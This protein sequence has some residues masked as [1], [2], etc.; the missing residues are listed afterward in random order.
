MRSWPDRGLR[1]ALLAYRALMWLL[2]PAILLYLRKRGRADP[3]YAARLRERFGRYDAP[4]PGAVWVHAVSMGEMRSAVP[5]IR[6][7][8]DRG[9][10][11]VTTHFTPAGLREAE[12]AFGPEIAAGRLRAVWV[13]LEHGRCWDRFLDAFRPRF[14]LVMEIEIWPRMIAV[15]ARRGVPIYLCNAQY[16]EKSFE[17]DGRGEGLRARVVA[18][19]AGA[20]VKSQLQ[21]DRFAATGLRDIEI[22]GEHRFDQPI[23]QA[24]VAAADALRDELRRG[25]PALTLT[26]VVEGEDATYIE[27]IRATPGTVFVYVPRAPERFDEVAGLLSEAGLRV[28]RRSEVLDEGLRPKAPIDCDVLLGDSMGE[29]YFYMAL[30]DRALV[31]GG[32]V[33]KG[34]HNVIEPLAL[35]KPVL[36][37]PHVW[38]IEYPIREAAAAG[39]ARVLDTPEELHAAVAEASAVTEGQID[40]F[41]E[42]HAGAVARTLSAL[43]ARGLL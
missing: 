18:G 28:A 37:G 23:P 24:Q 3:L 33:P 21:A 11:I 25:R 36:V 27:M 30:S 42:A 4:L 22:T 40:A 10:Q 1:R 14:G 35:K 29:M 7:L 38:T 16:P 41:Y 34:A 13:P 31:G 19:F 5:M 32:F 12:R 8:L 26:S 15:C 9:E 43:E 39:V 20:F 17:K 6:A 2:L